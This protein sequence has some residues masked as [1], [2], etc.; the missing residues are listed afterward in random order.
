MKKI[1]FVIKFPQKEKTVLPKN[2]KRKLSEIM[3][4][5]WKEVPK[6]P[7]LT[8]VKPLITYIRAHFRT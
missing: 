4:K 8:S 7:E 3:E 2:T 1:I 6:I 5:N